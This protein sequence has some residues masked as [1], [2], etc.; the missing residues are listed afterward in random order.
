MSNFINGRFNLVLCAIHYTPIHG[1]L[2]TSYKK[3]EGH[4]IL[5]DK[6][7]GI[8][9]IAFDEFDE[10][11]DYNTDREYNG[12]SDID[13]DSDNES[14]SD[15]DRVTHISNVQRLYR[16][17]YARLITRHFPHKIIRNYHN[18]INRPDYIKPEIGEC[19]ELI[20]GEQIVIIKTI[21]LKIIQ[22]KW[23]K[24]FAKRQAIIKYRSSPSSISFRQLTGKWPEYCIHMPGLNGLLS[25]NLIYTLEEFV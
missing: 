8:S 2:E 7:H 20:T 23:K 5:I 22:R 17:E 10:F 3:I 13:S 25:K 1:K 14:E 11:I 18:I 15:N 24:V 21:W 6:F 4:Y 16:N 12:D 19:F 9:G